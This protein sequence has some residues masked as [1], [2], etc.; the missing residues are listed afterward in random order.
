[1]HSLDDRPHADAKITQL[2]PRSDVPHLVVQQHGKEGTFEHDGLSTTIPPGNHSGA[3]VSGGAHYVQGMHSLDDR[4]HADAKTAHLC[5][6]SVVPHYDALQ[7]GKEGTFEHDGLSIAV[8]ILA[9]A[10]LA[11]A[12][13]A[14]HFSALFSMVM[15]GLLPALVA[16]VAPL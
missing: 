2:C 16:M 5:S 7:H 4:P 3:G 1:M 14:Q 15:G 10:I 11:Q 6:H 13:T 9:Q 12:C 8:A